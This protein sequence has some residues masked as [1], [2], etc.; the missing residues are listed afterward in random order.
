MVSPRLAAARKAYRRGGFGEVSTLG[1]RWAA[2]RIWPGQLPAEPKPEKPVPNPESA[3]VLSVDYDVAY[4]WFEKRR[5]NYVTLSEAVGP[6]LDRS[7]VIFDVG[8]NM[9]YFTEIL[10]EVTGFTGTAHLFEPLPHLACLCR[11]TAGRLPFRAEVHEF[12]L[13]DEDAL[14]DLFLDTTHG[15]LG[16]NTLESKKATAAMVRAQI[17]VHRFDECGIT[18]EPSFVKID[19]EGAEYRVLEGMLPA[20]ETWKAKPPFLIEVGWGQNHPDWTR[21][22]AALTRLCDLGYTTT[23]VDGTPLDLAGLT[24]TTDVLFLAN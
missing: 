21:D 1:R 12:G 20:V 17:R 2:R 9:G 8:A 7:G 15:N 18:V 4:A 23:A 24:K 6:H 5:A 13:G 16:W 19:V 22:L 14:L 3:P 11:R 10:G